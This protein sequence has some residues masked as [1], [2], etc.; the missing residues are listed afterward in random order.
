MNLKAPYPVNFFKLKNK[1]GNQ[2][3]PYRIALLGCVAAGIGA[4]AAVDASAAADVKKTVKMYGAVNRMAGVQ[5]DGGT[6]RFNHLDNENSVSVFGVRAKAKGANVA[7]QARFEWEFSLNRNRGPVAAQVA[8]NASNSSGR[9]SD[10][11]FTTN[12]GV[13]FM[14]H[15]Q[16]SSD[17]MIKADLSGT[18]LVMQSGRA[19]S[20][21]MSFI[22]KPAA[23]GTGYSGGGGA[24]SAHQVM[25]YMPEMDGDSRTNRIRYDTPKFAGFGLSIDNATGGRMN[26]AITYGAKL[27]GFKIKSKIAHSNNSSTARG[28]ED[29]TGGSISVL[30]NSGV[31]ATYSYVVEPNRTDIDSAQEGAA[32]NSP[33]ATGRQATHYGKVGY[34]ASFTDLGK[35]YMGVDFE[36]AFDGIVDGDRAT[37]IGVGVVQKLSAYGA[38]I[39]AAYERISAESG[40]QVGTNVAGAG[41]GINGRTLNFYDINAGYFGARV[42][43]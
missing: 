38:E 28:Q 5:A 40:N 2:M 32:P 8:V 37:K 20:S 16:S 3:K 33:R 30:H 31:S 29:M 27:G 4:M 21:N 6:V 14:G 23:A 7:I 10:I 25:D 19:L 26:Y 15:G 34:Q 24:N 18:T 35:T 12:Y 39:Y 41:T 36:R 42:K 22:G 17:N 9:Y 1:R 13:L 43:W 11:S